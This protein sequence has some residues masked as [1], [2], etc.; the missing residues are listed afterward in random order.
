MVPQST[1]WTKKL[2]RCPYKGLPVHYTVF[3][4]F[5]DVACPCGQR[6]SLQDRDVDRHSGR[7]VARQPIRSTRRNY[8]FQLSAGGWW[9]YIGSKRMCRE[10]QSAE[11]RAHK[12]AI[13]VNFIEIT[14]SKPNQRLLTFGLCLWRRSFFCTE[15]DLGCLFAICVKFHIFL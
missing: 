3:D 10:T 7:P 1:D 13:K 5:P 8:I 14:F 9:K 4:L 2:T 15:P 11:S 12:P 6:A